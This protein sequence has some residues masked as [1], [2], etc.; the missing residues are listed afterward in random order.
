MPISLRKPVPEWSFRKYSINNSE[1]V[2]QF[3]AFHHSCRSFKQGECD[4]PRWNERVKGRRWIHAT[5]V[6]PSV[7]ELNV[8]LIQDH[9]SKRDG[10]PAPAASLDHTLA[11]LW[12]IGVSL[13]TAVFADIFSE[14]IEEHD[15]AVYDLVNPSIMTRI[16]AGKNLE[17]SKIDPSGL[18]A[19]T[20]TISPN[21]RIRNYE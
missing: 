10:R 5:E 3:N 7:M 17:T 18:T 20:V 1:I 12:R 2:F 15:N 9:P 8:Q 14:R 16:T 21:L 4:Q 6:R 13:V 19:M 11:T